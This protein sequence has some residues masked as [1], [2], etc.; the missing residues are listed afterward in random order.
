M[1]SI[2]SF[3]S[4]CTCTSKAQIFVALTKEE[5]HTFELVDVQQL[6]HDVKRFRF[7]PQSIGHILHIPTGQHVSLKFTAQD[8]C[9]VIRSYSPTSSDRATGLVDICI[10]IYS[11][12]GRGMT[13]H[14][15]KLRIGD[16]ILMR[17]PEVCFC[18]CHHSCMWPLLCTCQHA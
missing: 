3:F 6:T 7:A 5:W 18:V 2:L 10:K 1:K 11:P 16:K 12:E 13:Q 9:D 4:R 14:V 8:G 17:G 15:N